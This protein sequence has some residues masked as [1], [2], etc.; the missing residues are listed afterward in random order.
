MRRSQFRKPWEVIRGLQQLSRQSDSF[1]REIVER[2]K[3]VGEMLTGSMGMRRVDSPINGESSATRIYDQRS[4]V[5]LEARSVTA[6]AEN[7]STN[8]LGLQD[9]TEATLTGGS[10]TGRGG[11]D[12]YGIRNS[13]SSAMLKCFAMQSQIVSTRNGL[14]MKSSN[15]ASR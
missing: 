8:N 4:G 11:G 14:P 3:A 9:G 7:G 6:L 2:T 5:M 12:A 13:G 10:F 15:P 1:S